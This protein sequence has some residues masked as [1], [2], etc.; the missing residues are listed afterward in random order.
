MIQDKIKRVV[1][2]GHKLHS[3]THSYIHY[4]FKKAFEHLNFEVYWFDD[5]DNIDN[6]CFEN[7]LFITEGQVDANIPRR[8]DCYYVLHNCDIDKYVDQTKKEN[9]MILQVFTTDVYKHSCKPVPDTKYTFYDSNC[10]Y[11]TWATDIL[12]HE[13]DDNIAK[14]ETFEKSNEVHFIGMSLEPWDMVEKFCEKNKLNY[15]CVGGFSG[16]NVDNKTNMEL[17]QKSIIAPAVQNIWQIE[18]GYVP[19]RIFKNISY[20]KMGVTNNRIVNELFDNQLICD[21]GVY[22]LMRKALAFENTRPVKKYKIIKN[23]MK[24]VKENHT[25]L[26]RIQSIFWFFNEILEHKTS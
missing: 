7:T 17:I 16:N 19:C 6:F 3:H 23:L 15:K 21:S 22:E 1:L 20:G 12:P 24:N 2:W 8:M 9:V 10:L 4:G 13:I 14:L 5:N 26:N 11:M 18:H 25:Y